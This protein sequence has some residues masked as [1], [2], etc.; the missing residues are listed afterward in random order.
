MKKNFQ[1]GV[2]LIITFFIL[3]IILAVVLSMSVVL[4]REIK[5]VRNIGNSVVSF[6]AADSGIEKVLYY[7]RKEKPIDVKSG[8]CG[9]CATEDP[10]C[11]D[12]SPIDQSMDCICDLPVGLDC[13][14]ESCESCD[15]S[16]S[17]NLNDE[18]V[19]YI[20]AK[21][22]T[23]NTVSNLIINSSGNFRKVKRAI[24][25]FSSKE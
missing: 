20:T 21:V 2:T 9:I 19:Y 3:T 12:S 15:I 13:D 25:V 16:F 18:A 23:E 4:Y 10:T 5:I 7:D 24:N 6:Y 22:S 8:V 17:T 14:P 11:P 1:K